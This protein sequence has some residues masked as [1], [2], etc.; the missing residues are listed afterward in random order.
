MKKFKIILQYLT[1]Y[2]KYQCLK[3]KNKVVVG[4]D[5]KEEN[6]VWC[7]WCGEEELK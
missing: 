2:T 5:R 6:F 4:K 1:G 7:I 3:C